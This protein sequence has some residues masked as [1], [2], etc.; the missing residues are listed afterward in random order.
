MA[1][2]PRRVALVINPVAGLGGTLALKGSDGELAERALAA[3]AIPG[4][5]RRVSAALD[6]LLRAGAPI[7]WFTVGGAMGADVLSE[8]GLEHTL[9]HTPSSPSKATDTRAAV[10]AAC[11][12][13]VDLLL[14]VGGDGTAR[15]VLAAA[16]SSLV[17]LGIPAGVKMHSAAFALTPRSAGVAAREYL[18]SESATGL[19]EARAVMDRE[20]D[21]DGNPKASPELFGYLSCLAMPSLVQAA[22]ATGAAGDEAALR[23]ALGRVAR[24]LATFDLALL[25]PGATL[26]ALKESMGVAP[27]LLGV[28][29]YAGGRCLQRDAREDQ[30]WDA[31]QDKRCCLALG[32]IGGQGFLLGRGNQQL[33]PRI[34]RQVGRDNLRVL[35]SREKLTAL[36]TP[37]LYVDTGDEDTDAMLAG[38]LPVITGPR[39]R[40]MFQ[41]TATSCS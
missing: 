5:P 2:S 30:I 27:T 23:G 18:Q 36:A 10:Q 39:Q 12:E 7:D 20:L 3:G 22:K 24:E 15:D 6:E 38:Y 40:L 13:S 19:V 29:L 33:S 4:A 14:F 9:L 16:D 32:V 17:V 28:D 35:A 11:A 1:L 8:R 41:V 26:A 25:G 37:T 31:I 21:R 34:L